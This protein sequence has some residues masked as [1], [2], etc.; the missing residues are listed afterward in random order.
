MDERTI[1]VGDLEL[2][3]A[4]AGVGGAPLMLLHGFTGGKDDFGDF[5]DRFGDSGWHAVAPDQRGHGASTKPADEAAYSLEL[6]A[7]DALA[8]ADELGWPRFALLGHSMGGMVAQQIALQA[9]ERLDALILMDTAHRSVELP[10]DMVEAAVGIVRTSGVARLLAIMKERGSALT[11]P[12]DIRVRAERP[13]YV[14]LGERK[15][16]ASSPAMYASMATVLVAQQDRLSGLRDVDVPSLVVVGEQDAPFLA[17][18]ERMAEAL[19]DGRLVV[20]ADAG[21]SPQFE[22]PEAWWSAVSGFLDGVRG[23]AAA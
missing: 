15:L 14:E 4:E 12:A 23:A 10:A 1:R 8:L 7:G 19:P 18:S 2:V 16:L 3:V 22:A 5:L 11:T 13:G 6:F 17:D 21:H 20:I 9:A